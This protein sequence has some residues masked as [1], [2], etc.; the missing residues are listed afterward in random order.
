MRRLWLSIDEL[1]RGRY[2]KREELRAGRVDIPTRTLIAGGLSLGALY[3]VFMGLYAAL[4]PTNPT[5][6]QLLATTV[7]L[8]LLFLLTLAVTIPSLVQ[9]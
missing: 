8:P 1:L 5:I 9:R 2:T 7:K 4:R 6:L 3:G